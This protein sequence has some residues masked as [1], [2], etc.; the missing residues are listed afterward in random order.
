MYKD[1]EDKKFDFLILGTNLTESALS[2]YL[3]KSKYKFNK[4][5]NKKGS[6]T[7]FRKRKFQ[8]I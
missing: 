6:S 4:S 2:A 3:A 1:L 5:R 7:C 8:T